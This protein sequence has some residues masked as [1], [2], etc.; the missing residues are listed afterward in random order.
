MPVNLVMRDF[1]KRR[2]MVSALVVADSFRCVECGICS[3]NCPVG[4]DVRL[5][6]RL[7]VPIAD[8]ACLSCG[9][10]VARCPR[11]TLRFEESSL[12]NDRATEAGSR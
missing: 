7:E 12:F 1:L 10:C 8:R 9:E 2:A 4:I 11:G 6:V 5:H 3:Y